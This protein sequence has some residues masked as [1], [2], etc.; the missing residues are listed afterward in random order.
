MEIELQT[1]IKVDVK[2]LEVSAGVRYWDDASVNGVEDTDGTLIPLRAED[3]WSPIIDLATGAV[4]NWP[5]GVTANIHYKVCDAGDYWLQDADGK[6]VAKW[7]GDYV[8]DRFLCQ[9]GEGFGDYIVMKI[10]AD[11]KIEDWTVPH[12]SIAQWRRL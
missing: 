11:G 3:N 7:T 9:Q 12:V 10:D 4:Q 5:S 1:T 8:P 6:R 2:F